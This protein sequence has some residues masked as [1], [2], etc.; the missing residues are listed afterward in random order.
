MI[1]ACVYKSGGIYTLDYVKALRNSV[2]KFAGTELWCLS[3][4]PVPTKRIELEYNFPGWWSKLELFWQDTEDDILYFDLD[5]L[6]VDDLSPLIKQ[7]GKMVMLQDF[8]VPKSLASGVMLIPK[9]FRKVVWD[10][11]CSDPVKYMNIRRGDGPFI[12]MALSGRMVHRWQELIPGKIV[13]FKPKPKEWL[14]SIP[15]GASVIC[16]HG[17][18]K[19]DALKD[20]AGEMW[21]VAVSKL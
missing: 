15:L 20:W 19:P 4:V 18:P 17:Q 16:F 11:F 12:E 8:Y 21:R 5:T 2:H 13:S 3:D 6:I 9:E 10:L 1:V 14:T 7:A